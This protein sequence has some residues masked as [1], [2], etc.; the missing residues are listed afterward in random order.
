VS[1]ATAVTEGSGVIVAAVT[2][3][4][5]AKVGLARLRS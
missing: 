4:V 3:R 2:D 1:E 5:E